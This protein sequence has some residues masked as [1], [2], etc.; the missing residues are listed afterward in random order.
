M[1]EQNNLKGWLFTTF[2]ALQLYYG[3]YNSPKEE[4]LLSRYS[5]KDLLLYLTGI[6]K[7]SINDIW[8]TAEINNKTKK[9]LIYWAT[10]YLKGVELLFKLLT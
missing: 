4:D 10:Y 8:H 7:V 3:I 6:R 5:P 2:I 1:K 9:A